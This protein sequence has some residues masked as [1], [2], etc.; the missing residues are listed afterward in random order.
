MKYKRPPK[1]LQDLNLMDRFLFS[2][3]IENAE[4]YKIILE[5]VLDK[6]FNF[7]EEPIAENEKRKELLGK[8]ARLDICAIGDDDRIYN[9]EVQKENHAVK[10]QR[11]TP[12][13]F[14]RCCP[15]RLQ[16]AFALWTKRHALKCC[17]SDRGLTIGSYFAGLSLPTCTSV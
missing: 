7:K 6:E 14:V 9:A 10:H 1:R 2:E 13:H 16:I 4:A 3:V 12:T 15:F 8:I 17:A 5:I 11:F